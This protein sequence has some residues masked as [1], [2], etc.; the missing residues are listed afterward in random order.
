MNYTVE[1]TVYEDDPVWQLDINRRMG[2]IKQWLPED[3][4]VINDEELLGLLA[5]PRLTE[6]LTG[7]SGSLEFE[8]F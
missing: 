1:P 8:Q 3:A 6:P 5:A 2:F 7:L 4:P